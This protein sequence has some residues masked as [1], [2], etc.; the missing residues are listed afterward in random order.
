MRMFL[1]MVVMLVSVV[2]WADENTRVH[3]GEFSQGT[4]A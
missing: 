3:V 4:L 2:A 1:T